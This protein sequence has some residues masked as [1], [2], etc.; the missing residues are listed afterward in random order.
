MGL[1]TLLPTSRAFRKIQDQPGRYNLSHL[2]LPRFGPVKSAEQK[3]P[4][5]KAPEVARTKRP[6]APGRQQL[7]HDEPNVDRQAGTMIMRRIE[8]VF[9]GKSTAPLPA[10]EPAPGAA[11]PGA[12]P[13]RKWRSLF[14]GWSLFKNPFNRGTKPKTPE[15]VGTVQ[16]EL[17]LERVKPVRNDLSDSDLE[18]IPAASPV[19]LGQPESAPVQALP[20]IPVSAVTSGPAPDVARWSGIRRQFRD[21]GKT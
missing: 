12:T 1:M 14:G 10:P 11:L 8:N 7:P 18:V 19:A 9:R 2:G 15:P 13:R 16:P 21:A 3:A 6:M 5:Q 4:E 17:W 20:P